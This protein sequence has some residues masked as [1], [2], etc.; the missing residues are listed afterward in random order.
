[1][2]RDRFAYRRRSWRSRLGWFLRHV[3]ADR[4]DHAN[5]PRVMHL[6]FTFEP[7]RGI[8]WHEDGRGCPVAYLSQEQY[9]WA[10]DDAL[11]QS[12]R[13]CDLHRDPER[14]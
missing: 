6:S 1:M 13:L 8:V 10:H 7:H 14:P 3:L 5:A 2:R 9:E 4:I 12:A 11:V